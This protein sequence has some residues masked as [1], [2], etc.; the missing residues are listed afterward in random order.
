MVTIAKA[1]ANPTK[2]FFVRM[3]TRDIS[4]EDCIL[5]LIDNSIDGAWQL[6]GG[7]RMSLDI[8]TDLSHYCVDIQIQENSFKIIDNCGG[9]TL[10]EA[11]EYAFTFGRKDD[12]EHESYSIGVYGIGM[13][14]AVFKIGKDIK[15][16]STYVDNNKL[17]SFLVP[18]N[19]D[20][21]LENKSENSWDFDIENASNLKLSGVEITITNLNES[22]VNAFCDPAFILNLKRILARDYTLHLR[23]GLKIK[24]NGE[25]LVGWQIELR[26]G[27][28]FAPM[29][30]VYEEDLDGEKVM[31]EIL[32]GM[33]TPPP[34]DTDPDN[35]RDGKK[36]RSGWYVACNGRI[37]LDADTSELSGWGTSDWP[38]WHPQYA[39][40][41][42]LI[43][44]TSENAELLP[45]TT[46]KRSVDPSS[47]VFRRAFPKMREVTKEWISY[48]NLRKQNLDEAK[49]RE[50]QAKSTSIY[51]IP[52]RPT[53][54][55]ANLPRK[56]KIAMANIAYSM[57]RERVRA[58]AAGFG[59]INL[60]YKD[61]GI[62]SFEYSYSDNVGDE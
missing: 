60:S 42:G 54:A 47:G 25:G 19:V 35:D 24:L 20:K 18:I 15:I 62:K 28:D 55:L 23:R 11:V 7:Q 59:N 53:V 33:S 57:P 34:E 6:E 27:G 40:F 58:L 39:G 49:Q 13:K 50:A 32:A 56:P 31:V 44:F 1:H 14:R 21:W 26:T 2:A 61:V 3:I 38:R 10:D 9:I 48:T 29:R 36:D 30:L 45:I 52:Q 12:D 8:D 41:L 16:H 51:E 5:D 43:V 46:T 37:V 4:L 17:H 22:T